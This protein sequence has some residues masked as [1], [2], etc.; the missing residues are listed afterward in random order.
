MSPEVTLGELARRNANVWGDRVAY[1]DERRSV[2]WKEIHQR[3]DA[4]A[5]ALLERGIKKGDR[6]AIISADCIEVAE[7]V[8]A[9]AKIGAIRVGINYRLAPREIAQLINDS[10]PT[11]VL[12]CAE[13]HDVVVDMWSNERVSP[14][15]IGFG[16][17]HSCDADYENLITRHY[18][19][20]N[21]P[22]DPNAEL[23]IC[24]TTGST[25]TPKGAVY[26]HTLFLRSMFYIALAEGVGHDDVWL[27]VMPASGIPIMHMLRNMF[28]ASKCAILGEWN[29]EKALKFIEQERCSIMVLVPTMVI[30]LIASGI[31]RQFDVSSVRQIGYGAAPIPPAI[32]REAMKAFSCKFLQ[33]YGSTELMGMAMML[34]PSD[35]EEALT[36][37]PDILAAAGRPLP[38]VEIKIVN[39]DGD[40]VHPGEVGE[41]LV[42]SEFMISEYYEAPELREIRNEFMI[43]EYYASPDE[44]PHPLSNGWLRT[45]DLARQDANGFVYLGD[46]VKFRI[47]SGGY[48]V[49][50]TE[51]EN[52]LAEHPN[53]SEVAVVGIP[54]EKWGERVH[55]VVTKR[56][57]ASL[58]EDS[59]RAFCR[60]QIADFKI[61]K[62]I[63]VWDDIPKGPTG[64]V[65]KKQ[66]IEH[67]TE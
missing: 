63:D 44:N 14:D 18:S 22:Q 47:K 34:F 43:R 12:I 45:G 60:G 19:T 41:L 53:I 48:N 16:G 64:K 3:T 29:C 8:V 65:Q 39:E 9:C 36:V 5:R 31:V 25:G 15:I 61:P 32:I 35:H 42:K 37:A 17:E 24:Y 27:H 33:M 55:A 54:D 20:E 67:Y 7:H 28:H 51:I 10:D 26:S 66:I 23:M 62:T 4:F 56:G 13:L 59:L 30:D 49:I 57:T 50:P 40:E 11:V 1:V 58:S 2:T 6:V 52:V 46:R 21:L 38:Y